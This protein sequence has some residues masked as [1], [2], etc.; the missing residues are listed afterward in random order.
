VGE[1]VGEISGPTRRHFVSKDYGVGLRG[2]GVVLM[3]RDPQLNFRRRLR[4]ARKERIVYT[5]IMLKLEQM[6][7]ADYERRKRIVIER[8]LEEIPP[9]LRKYAILDFD[10]DRFAED[11]KSWLT[12]QMGFL[13]H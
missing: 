5:D 2:V 10:E 7:H 13:R 9:V 3:C 6:R 12:E 8:L 4:F 11:L 1:L